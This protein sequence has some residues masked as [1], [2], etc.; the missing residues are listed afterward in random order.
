MFRHLAEQVAYGYIAA[1]ASGVKVRNAWAKSLEDSFHLMGDVRNPR[2]VVFAY[3][4][5]RRTHPWGPLS[6][7]GFVNKQVD[8]FAYGW[9]H[10]G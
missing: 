9:A 1:L 8:K 2:H 7:G 5:V 10:S 3:L 4:R 6:H